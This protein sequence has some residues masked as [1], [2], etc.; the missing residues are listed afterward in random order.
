MLRKLY[1]K[2][3][4]TIIMEKRG[5][6]LASI[7]KIIQKAGAERVSDAAKEE[8]KRIIEENI[9]KISQRAI[10]LAEHAGRKTIKKEDIQLSFKQT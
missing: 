5:I 6:P 7:E 10:K 1:K 8:M 9:F 3:K 2:E 4:A